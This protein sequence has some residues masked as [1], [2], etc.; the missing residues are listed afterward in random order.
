MQRKLDRTAPGTL[1]LCQPPPCNYGYLRARARGTS[2]M[3]RRLHGCLA[4]P[5]ASRLLD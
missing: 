2:I 5:D 1:E 3:A 4:T